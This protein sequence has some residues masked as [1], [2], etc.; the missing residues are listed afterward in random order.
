MTEHTEPESQCA[1]CGRPKPVPLMTRQIAFHV[2]FH[3]P[4]GIYRDVIIA[5]SPVDALQRA[6]T[7]VE[8]GYLPGDG[9]DPVAESFVIQKIIV[10]HPDGEEEQ[11][12][13]TE[14]D[15]LAGTHGAEILDLLNDLLGQINDA[16]DAKTQLDQEI[17][18]FESTAENASRRLNCL[19]VNGGAA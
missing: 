19:G 15:Y 12:A 6:R 17:E 13:W 14:P 11:A 9:F 18:Q 7:R 16:I 3:A 10:A 4:A 1:A 8:T 5:D 2:E